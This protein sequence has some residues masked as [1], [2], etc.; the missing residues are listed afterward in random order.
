MRLLRRLGNVARPVRTLKS[1]ANLGLSLG[2][3]WSQAVWGSDWAA[4]TW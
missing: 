3:A 4:E 1:L 2:R